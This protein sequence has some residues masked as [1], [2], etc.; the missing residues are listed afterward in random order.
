[1]AHTLV[2]PEFSRLEGNWPC[3][4]GADGSCHWVSCFRHP[5]TSIARTVDTRRET[6]ESGPSPC[7]KC[8]T[9]VIGTQHHPVRQVGM[10]DSTPMYQ[11]SRRST[12]RLGISW[13][14]L[15]LPALQYDHEEV[16]KTRTPQTPNSEQKWKWAFLR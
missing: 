9:D 12:E 16:D 15:V 11:H 4:D 7:S 13:R 6:S 10:L 3:L 2:G 8:A 1:M 14:L 5:M